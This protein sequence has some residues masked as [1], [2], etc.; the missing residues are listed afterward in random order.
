MNLSWLN[1]Y[2]DLQNINCFFVNIT[3]HSQKATAITNLSSKQLESIIRWINLIIN[4]WT[5]RFESKKWSDF[6]G[7][8]E[9][10]YLTKAGDNILDNSSV[11]LKTITANYMS[12]MIWLSCSKLLM[13]KLLLLCWK[14]WCLI[15]LVSFTQSIISNISK[16]SSFYVELINLFIFNSVTMLKPHI[17]SSLL[18]K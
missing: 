9:V 10:S 6:K 15:L 8:M 4:Q 11:N 18:S 3:R 17:S 5:N 13:N 1:Q 12:L 14:G 16:T 7:H 2:R